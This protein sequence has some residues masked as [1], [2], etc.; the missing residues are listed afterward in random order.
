MSLPT[1]AIGN[2]AGPPVTRGLGVV[3]T[4]LVTVH[5]GGN[6]ILERRNTAAI[7]SWRRRATAPQ[8]A[9][10]PH[11]SLSLLD[12]LGAMDDCGPLL[13]ASFVTQAE[14]NRAVSASVA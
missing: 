6:R 3:V 7:D 10:D 4:E 12:G 2:A 14:G 1:D 13:P 9:W 8:I 11:A 5:S